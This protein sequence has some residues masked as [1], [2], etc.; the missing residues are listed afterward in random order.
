MLK[1]CM[2]H[3]EQFKM[4]SLALPWPGMGDLQYPHEEVAEAI[5]EAAEC[6]RDVLVSSTVFFQI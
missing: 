5:F 4:K 3:V 2:S 1:E 6:T